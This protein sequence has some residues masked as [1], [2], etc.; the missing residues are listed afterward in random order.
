[1]ISCARFVNHSEFVSNAQTTRAR[2]FAAC[3]A[4][5]QTVAVARR[6]GRVGAAN[7]AVGARTQTPHNNAHSC[8]ESKRIA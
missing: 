1:V 5:A 6:Y 8:C 2:A 4:T 3:A 7:V